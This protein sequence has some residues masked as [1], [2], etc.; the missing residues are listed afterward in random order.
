MKRTVFGPSPADQQLGAFIKSSEPVYADVRETLEA[1]TESGTWRRRM[2]SIYGKP[3]YA[4]T[5]EGFTA[6][7]PQG[8]EEG[9][10]EGSSGKRGRQKKNKSVSFAAGTKGKAGKA[11]AT[12]D[13]DQGEGHTSR[14]SKA[15]ESGKGGVNNQKSGNEVGRY[16]EKKAIFPYEDGS[17]SNGACE[18]R[19]T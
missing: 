15:R 16:V 8:H 12:S 4:A 2:G 18:P 11:K 1:M 10:S 9:G 13:S 14:L 3:T 17:F 5:P 6:V 19:T 7:Q